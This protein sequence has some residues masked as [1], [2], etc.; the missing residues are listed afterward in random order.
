MSA[1]LGE[2]IPQARNAPAST[3]VYQLVRLRMRNLRVLRQFRQEHQNLEAT[4]VGTV[5]NLRKF[6]K[7][8]LPGPSQS[9]RSVALS[10]D[11]IMEEAARAQNWLLKLLSCH[12]RL[13]S[14]EGEIRMFRCAVEKEIAGQREK[15]SEM[16]RLYMALT[17]NELTSPQT[18][19]EAGCAL[20]FQLNLAERLRDVSE[21]AAIKTEQIQYAASMK[22]EASQIYETINMRAQSMI[23]DH[24]ACAVP[25]ANIARTQTS[26]TDENAG[27]CV[28]CQNSY[29]ALSAFSVPDLLSDYPVRIKHCGHIVGKACLEE[30]MITPKIEEAKYPYRTCPMCRVKIEGVE[31]PKMPDGLLKHLKTDQRAME[32][33]REM[34]YGW[35]LELTECLDVVVGTMSE[36]IAAEQLLAEIA[37]ERLQGKDNI[38]FKTGEDYL[39]AKAETLKKQRWIWGFRG[40]IWSQLRDE[41]MNSG[42]VRDD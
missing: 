12:D 41:W 34:Y 25:L 11:E 31:A 22:A 28:I 16:E 26:I 8:H 20:V 33:V 10:D 2:W 15:W 21:R 39:R 42:V 13:L 18:K 24:F 9:P 32:T 38:L 4:L 29:T 7:Q 1:E 19:L 3:A 30:W 5:G 14:R 23:I 6:D 37:R 35:D 27:C 17:D 36:E 40:G